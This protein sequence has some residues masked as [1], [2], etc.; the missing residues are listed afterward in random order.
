[1]KI[2]I[3][4]FALVFTFSNCKNKDIDKSVISCG[5]ETIVD[6]DDYISAATDQVVIN[7]LSIDGDCLKIYYGASGCNGDSWIVKLIDSEE[8]IDSDTLQRNLKFSLLNNEI[9]Q[10]Y[11]TKEITFDISNL[12]VD[13]GKVMLNIFDRGDE[14]L[15]EY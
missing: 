10:A 12:Q 14:I 3:L 13:G 11:F 4:L 7:N 8:I 15:Y 6:A 2:T 5:A 1:M 9:C